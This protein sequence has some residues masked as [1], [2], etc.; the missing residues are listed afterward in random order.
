MGRT[1][2]VGDIH[3]AYRALRQVLER[4][5]FDRISDRL[6]CLGDVT[7]GWP[8]TKECIDELLGI[9]NLIYLMGN[10]D[11]WASQW[12]ETREAE[13]IW[14]EQGGRATCDSYVNGVP[15]NHLEFFKNA[16][17]YFVENNRLFVHAGVMPERRAEECSDY[18]LFW[19]RTLVQM[20]KHHELIK[21]GVRLTPYD[22]VY[23]GH[24]PINTHKPTKYCEV[25]MMDTGAAWSGELSI[26]NVDTKEYFTSDVVQ[27][28][29]PGVK[30][31]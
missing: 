2:V 4:S 26:M 31:R 20:A 30:G 13:E 15:E 12:M 17:P 14:L 1:F 24:T 29:Y 27:D 23:V 18:T 6:I 22:E 9:P 3:G 7:D 8:E 5:G 16:K 25:W 11:V 10:H 19:D 21:S 28:L